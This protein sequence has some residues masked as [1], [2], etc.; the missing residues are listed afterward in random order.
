MDFEIRTCQARP[1]LRTRCGGSRGAPDSAEQHAARVSC[2]TPSDSVRVRPGRA[3]TAVLILGF[4]AHLAMA[5]QPAQPPAKPTP[6]ESPPAAL[7]RY[8]D[9]ANFQNNGAFDLAVD[10]W[11]RFLKQ[12]PE[13]PL[14]AKA[15]HYLGVC[16]L[17]LKQ[18]A[19]AAKAFQTVVDK[20]PEFELLEDTLLNL[21]WCQYSLGKKGDLPR[22]K[23]AT[24]T[25]ARLLKAF[26]K[27]KYVDQALYFSGE[28]EYA[29]GNRKEA[30]LA[31]GKL[32]TTQTESKL[33]CDSLYALGVT[34]EE[35]RE[36][37]NARKAYDMFLKDF[38]DN[39][40]VPEVR[41]RKAETVLQLG[42]PATAEGLFAEV[43][44]V[45]GFDAAD[46]ALL[47]QALCAAR[48]KK[49]VEAA[50]LNAALVQR[51]PKS[52][53][54]T[55]AAMSA[56][57]AYYQATKYDDAIKWFQQVIAAAGKDTVEA[58]HWLCR[59][60][61]LRGEPAK[62][63]AVAGQVI[64]TA[65][66]QPYASNLKLDEADGLYATEGKRQEALDRYLAIYKEY[67]D[68]KV[69]SQALYDAAF[70]AMELQQFDR[71]SD[72][73][74]KF[75][76][77]YPKDT[78]APDARYVAAECWLQRKDY[79]KA[80]SDFRRL[81]KEYPGHSVW[82]TWQTRLG[83]VLYLQK[84]YADTVDTLSAALANLKAP[85]A[86]A[87]ARYLIGLAH[88]QLT[89][90]PE[91][92]KSLRASLLADAR[93]RQADET[94]LY[95]ARAQFKMKQFEQATTT[96]GL[97][98][99]TYTDS[100]LLDQAA[101]RL[102][103]FRYAAGEFKDALTAY[104]QVLKEWPQSEFV[105]FALYGKGWSLLKQNQYGEAAASFTQLIDQKPPHS[106]RARAL[107]ARGMCLRQEGKY[108]DAIADID[109]YLKTNPEAT[110]RADALYE[111]GLAEA[112]AKNYAKAIES[113]TT[114]LDELPRYS[115]ADRV[116]YEL[117][118]AY[119]SD[120]KHA[121]AV[122]TF[123]AL[124]KRHPTSDLAAEAWF[125][126]AEDSYSNKQ[127][128]EAVDAYRAGLKTATDLA[129]KE[130]TIYKLG[131]AYFQI[132]QYDKA[133]EQFEAQLK[134]RPDGPLVADA[135]F[136]KAECLFK[137]KQYQQAM[138][139]FE[140]AGRREGNTPQIAAMIM[141]HGAQSA[142]QLEQWEDV[143]AKIEP[144]FTKFPKSPYLADAYFER[145]R[146]RQKLN[147][148]D[149][150]IQDYQ[151][152]A[153]RSRGEVGARAQFMIGEIRF[154]R[155]EYDMAIKDF[156]RVMYRLG[157]DEVDS[158][159]EN[160]QAKAAFEAGRCAELRIQS[161]KTVD[162]KKQW[163]ADAVKFY[164]FIVDRYPKHELVVQASRRLEAL[165]GLE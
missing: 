140:E 141:L 69:A 90:Y 104:D 96:I 57:R 14:A 47:R 1:M 156:Q 144:L 43:A 123:A 124:A 11:T 44:S 146:A 29:L 134:L 132:K 32:V 20:Y 58:A 67:P 28:S 138:A 61:L 45:K 117:A 162:E 115:A 84:K 55:E 22:Y 73:A 127:Y 111:R 59:I 16:Q 99:K 46:Y 125:H 122:R 149:A 80:E 160:W 72:L 7:T 63:V 126:V 74:R 119:D 121:D 2:Q 152:A 159:V 18:F 88:F 15:M 53:Y 82:Q 109:Q 100:K 33:R 165:S 136:L 143:V 106:L 107:L 34:L 147:Q 157:G 31:Y 98:Q 12:F 26:P 36:Y 87:E 21:G 64:P 118:W 145:G 86:V 13:D 76:D 153:D 77:T 3:L 23:E 110:A 92:A 10:E 154:G 103:E 49:Y 85:E 42:D 37:A 97:L 24:A 142:G 83:L 52:Q 17:Q 93:W 114:L 65:K 6:K 105:P 41:M 70:A 27:G 150:A 50:N 78:L 164:R 95:L 8:A 120:G 56:G 79:V 139:A 133:L 129:L 68:S 30:A 155:K 151:Q 135:C 128:E 163:T 40:L 48:Q 116:M 81:V 130:K 131:W 102:G 148:Q 89:Q 4:L 19:D 75:L 113:Y 94:T 9:A 91:A 137:T 5:Q 101:Y 71:A 60:Y 161:A 38:A 62:A 39:S 35:M 112:A 108:V 54:V 25:F 158:G 51:F 66:D